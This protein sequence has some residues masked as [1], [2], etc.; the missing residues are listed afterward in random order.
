M[1]VLSTYRAFYLPH[2]FALFLALDDVPRASAGPLPISV[3]PY[4][5]STTALRREA[6]RFRPGKSLTPQRPP[7][8]L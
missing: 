8:T 4:L 3:V 5:W 6:P 2:F 1:L 7:N